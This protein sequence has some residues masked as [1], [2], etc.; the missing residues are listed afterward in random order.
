MSTINL[1]DI[2][3]PK[4]DLLR[5]IK[6][7]SEASTFFSVS[8]GLALAAA[9]FRQLEIILAIAYVV[10]IIYTI[11]TFEN[12]PKSSAFRFAAITLGLSVGIREILI[13][14]WVPMVTSIVVVI[15]IGILGFTA[16]RYLEAG[17]NP[18]VG[19]Q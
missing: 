17:L 7:L 10:A 9:Y 8:L 3:T 1:E 16:W 19:G 12:N 5:H 2:P 18:K 11:L 14:F 15:A 13:F 4:A 6:N